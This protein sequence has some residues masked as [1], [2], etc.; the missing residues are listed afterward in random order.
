MIPFNFIY[1]ESLKLQPVFP[2][3]IFLLTFE[4][5]YRAEGF[6]LKLQMFQSFRK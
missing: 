2:G 4:I 6:Q 5:K 1:C 3:H